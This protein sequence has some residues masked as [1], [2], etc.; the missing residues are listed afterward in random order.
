MSLLRRIRESPVILRLMTD[1]CLTIAKRY[2]V[3]VCIGRKGCWLGRNMGEVYQL[4]KKKKE[5]KKGHTITYHD[6]W[7][8]WLQVHMQSVMLIPL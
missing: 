6:G 2:I 4:N 5:K 1:D 7:C 3:C 8:W